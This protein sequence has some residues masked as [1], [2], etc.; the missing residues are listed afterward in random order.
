MKSSFQIS[1]FMILAISIMYVYL[2]IN[3]VNEQFQQ[4]TT[5]SFNTTLINDYNCT[6]LQNMDVWDPNFLSSNQWRNF[7]SSYCLMNEQYSVT[8]E[9]LD[10]E[11]LQMTS[12]WANAIDSCIYDY[13]KSVK[14]SASIVSSS[15]LLS[16]VSFVVTYILL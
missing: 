10:N 12:V 14:S 9:S 3:T 13:C 8:M 15:Y 4:V 11:N 5:T 6:E 7:E 1:D 2:K 16:G